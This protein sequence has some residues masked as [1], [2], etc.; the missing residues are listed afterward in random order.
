MTEYPSAVPG[1]EK[2][3]FF[4]DHDHEEGGMADDRS[5]S[6]VF[7]A[8]FAIHLAIHLLKQGCFEPG[9]FLHHGSVI[10]C[11]LRRHCHRDSVSGAASAA[12][13]AQ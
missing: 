2:T 6:N 12:P 13:K 11:I 10:E 7:E 9:L 5:K 1:M 3:L 8:Q 4:F